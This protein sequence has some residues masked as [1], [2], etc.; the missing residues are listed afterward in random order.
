MNTTLTHDGFQASI[1][2]SGAELSSFRK[3]DG[4]E[5]IWQADP[6]FWNRHS[7]VLFPIVG[8]LKGGKYSYM[9]NQYA[10]PR[11][12]FARDLA[13][14]LTHSSEN[15]AV[16]SLHFNKETLENYPFKFWL[17]INY[18]LQHNTLLIGYSVINDGEKKMPFS[19]GAHPAFFLPGD[20]S[21]YSLDFGQAESLKIQLLEDGLLQSQTK[22]L[23]LGIDHH[24]PLDYDLFENDALIIRNNP[25]RDL[26]ILKNGERYLGVSFDGFP[27]L[28]LWSVKNAP[29]LCIE[30]WFGY[31]DPVDS[32]GVIFEKEG[33]QMLEP[34]GVFNTNFS[35]SLF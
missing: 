10:L 13:F 35:I 28:G 5:Y 19:I 4:T 18:R 21:E 24:L 2:F 12:G 31:S 15:Q 7:P 8:S 23:P 22:V 26:T 17:Q 1:N 33:I 34:G 29:F 9:G 20:F 3:P 16:F 11:H 25:H 32:S 30:P 14:D 6:K 27:H